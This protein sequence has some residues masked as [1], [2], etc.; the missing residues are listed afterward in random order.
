M[1]IETKSPLQNLPP[2]FQ[3]AE[4]PIEVKF[5]GPITRPVSIRW[6]YDGHTSQVDL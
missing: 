5:V 1:W 6:T 3:V 2:P 4:A